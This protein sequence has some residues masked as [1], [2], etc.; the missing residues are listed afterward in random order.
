[1]GC[2]KYTNGKHPMFSDWRKISFDF[3]RD[4]LNKEIREVD[5]IR[6]ID[7]KNHYLHLRSIVFDD[8]VP[9]DMKVKWSNRLI[10]TA[11]KIIYNKRII[12]L[13]TKYHQAHPDEILDTLLHEMTHW[14]H[15]N[16]DIDDFQKKIVEL[17][18]KYN[19]DMGVFM[20]YKVKR[21]PNWQYWCKDCGNEFTL[22]RKYPEHYICARCEGEFGY[23][24]LEGGVEYTERKCNR[25]LEI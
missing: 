4:L 2:E 23:E 7:L 9:K 12:K 13:N 15:R 21:K 1:M 11:G 25:G 8:E 17:N 20:K 10:T 5:D 16:H 3:Q 14:N 24:E 18:K 19:M 22:I 6:N